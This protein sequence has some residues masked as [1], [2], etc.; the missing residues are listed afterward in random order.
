MTVIA[1][2]TRLYCGKIGENEIREED[3]SQ[4]R[5][6][7]SC[8]EKLG[9]REE[10]LDLL[11][12]PGYCPSIDPPSYTPAPTIYPPT[13]AATTIYANTGTKTATTD[14][15]TPTTFSSEDDEEDLSQ[16]SNLSI[17]EAID[18]ILDKTFGVKVPAMN[19]D[20]EYEEE[21]DDDDEL[22]VYQFMTQAACVIRSP[23]NHDGDSRDDD[24]DDVESVR[25]EALHD[26]DADGNKVEIT[27]N[28]YSVSVKAVKNDGREFRNENGIRPKI[29]V[30]E[31]NEA[32]KLVCGNA[33]SEAS[34]VTNSDSLKQSLTSSH[35]TSHHNSI[36]DQM[37]LSSPASPDLFGDEGEEETNP[38]TEDHVGSDNEQEPALSNRVDAVV[39]DIAVKGAVVMDTVPIVT[40]LKDVLINN[41]ECERI[42]PDITES[43]KTRS[44][45]I[46]SE[47]EKLR[48]EMTLRFL[49]QSL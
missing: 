43:P 24:D 18:D 38:D 33:S 17:N 46:K 34:D 3:A 11:S 15:A 22:E 45:D 25:R 19:Q 7:R 1:V 26:A 49:G 8:G 14:A 16:M 6:L 48:Y 4:R 30:E 31:Q 13:D 28:S 12:S 44:S 35:F 39:K 41:D 2:L 29:V 20:F 40:V 47:A 27:D 23:M 9:L 37:E 32:A 10:V 42:S 36:D 21:D 5:L